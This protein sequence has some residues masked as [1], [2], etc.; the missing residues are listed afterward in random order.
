MVS[1]ICLLFCINSCGVQDKS[2]LSKNSGSKSTSVAIQLK[3]PRVDSVLQFSSM[4]HSIFEDS[5]GNMW[6]G[7][8]CDGFC[9]YDPSASTKT[10]KKQFTYFT[11]EN[12]IPGAE[13]INFNDRDVPRGNSVSS[14]TEDR[15][16]HLMFVTLGGI[17]QF[18]GQSFTAIHPEKNSLLITQSFDPLQKNSATAW[19][20]EFDHLWFGNS[21]DNGAFRY[22]GKKLTQLIFPISTAFEN[23][24]SRQYATYSLYKDDNENIWFGTESAGIM[25]YNGADFICI[26]EQ[27][28][29]GIVRAFFQDHS[30]KVWISNV[31]RGLHYYDHST[32]QEGKPF[33]IN[34][35]KAMGNHTLSEIRNDNS[36]DEAKMLDGIQ[37][38]EQDRQGNLWFGSFSN[39][40]WRY[41]GK[42][43]IHYNEKNG[44]PSNTIKTIYKDKSGKL[45]FGMGRKQAGVY[46][47][48]GTSF[49]QF[50]GK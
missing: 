46:H 4:I 32:H 50:G 22:D 15:E 13:K 14:I 48:N 37:T 6:F 35:T 2:S 3:P 38:I 30:G 23:R 20:K 5:E 9:K 21:Q 34:F 24:L 19:K 44:L 12:G 36:L 25:R 41:D 26:N 18:D 49:V 33:F 47:F 31:L 29:K 28:E 10:G 17:V 39:G 1:A 43:I 40:L 45:W 27:E 11:V 7:S 42:E 16:G 8:W